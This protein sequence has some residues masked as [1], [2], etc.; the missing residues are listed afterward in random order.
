MLIKPAPQDW[1]RTGGWL[2]VGETVSAIGW[3]IVSRA[4][5]DVGIREVPPGSNRGTR[6]ER[7]LRRAGVP[8][9]V[10]KAGKGY[11][12]AAFVGAVYAD[13]G[14]PVP[15]GYA[16]CDAWIP[17]LSPDARVGSAVLYGLRKAGGLDAHHVGI[18]VR[19]NPI[20]TI[21]GNR[22]F[23]GTTSNDG[24]ACDYG[25]MLRRDVLGYIHPE[26]LVARFREQEA[27]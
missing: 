3:S 1:P 16:S 2:V 11:W 15:A 10:I 18:V 23:A 9:D 14:L 6:I 7:Y 20:D 21:E 8:E 27:A 13:C 4:F 12:C 17:Y 22:A 5:A 25:P 26:T 24:V 19:L